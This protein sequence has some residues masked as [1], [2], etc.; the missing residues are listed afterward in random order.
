MAETVLPKI[1]EK[2]RP[3]KGSNKILAAGKSSMQFFT[4]FQKESEAINF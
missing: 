1:K 4:M 3:H 2:R